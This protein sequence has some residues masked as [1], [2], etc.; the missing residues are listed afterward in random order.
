M[1]YYGIFFMGFVVVVVIGVCMLEK[2]IFKG[3]RFK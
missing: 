1:N 3:R 2:N